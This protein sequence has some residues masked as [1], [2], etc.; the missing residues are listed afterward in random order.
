MNDS[1]TSFTADVTYYAQGQ[2][3]AFKEV[4]SE[5]WKRLSILGDM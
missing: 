5:Q 2:F 1:K 4:F 3:G